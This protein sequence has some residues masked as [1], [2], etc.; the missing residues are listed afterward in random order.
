[1]L[2]APE[3]LHFADNMLIDQ[4][5]IYKVRPIFEHLNIA[6]RVNTAEEFVSIDEKMVECYNNYIITRKPVRFGYKLW[7]AGKSDGALHRVCRAMMWFHCG[8]TVALRTAATTVSLPA[9]PLC[10]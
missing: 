3:C 10:L 4:D 8:S 2:R 1:M 6:M 9:A 7:G 5:S